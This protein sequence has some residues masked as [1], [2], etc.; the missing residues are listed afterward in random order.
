MIK[1]YKYLF[2]SLCII[3]CIAIISVIYIY[4]KGDE[5]M[6]TTLNVTSLAF[7]NGSNIPI[8]Y[9]G[10]GEDISIPLEF[11]NVNPKGKYIA[12]IMDDPDA[13][14]GTFTHWLIWNILSTIKN[15]PE[16]IPNDKEVS[17]LDGALQGKNGMGNIGYMGPNPPYGTHTYRIKVY[18]LDSLLNLKAGSSK[19]ALESAIKGHTI[20]T[21]LLEGKFSR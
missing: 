7:K 20:Q 3:L 4:L 12:I 9:T 16:N 11:N 10:R 18:V 5:K 1:K 8:K 15:I 19:E 21:G 6:D 14:S 17:S 2:I 13:P